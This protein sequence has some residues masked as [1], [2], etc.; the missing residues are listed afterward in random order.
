MSTTV[1]VYAHNLVCIDLCGT[2]KRRAI[3]LIDPAFVDELEKEFERGR[4]WGCRHDLGGGGGGG[5]GALTGEK[6]SS[7]SSSYSAFSGDCASLDPQRRESELDAMLLRIC[8]AYNLSKLVRWIFQNCRD[9]FRAPRLDSAA[10]SSSPSSSASSRE[11][12]IDDGDVQYDGIRSDC[13]A[14][15]DECYSVLLKL[16]AAKTIEYA[17]FLLPELMSSSASSSSRTMRT[18]EKRLEGFTDYL[19]DVYEA[20]ERRLYPE[21]LVRFM[22]ELWREIARCFARMIAEMFDR[23]RTWPAEDGAETLLQSISYLV[24]FMKVILECQTWSLTG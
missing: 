8:N 14:R 11:G 16:L 19:V 3:Q 18:I 21:C 17:E 1:R 5:G 2:A 15:V 22:A 10:S 4:V 6:S 24:K 7:S 9:S 23:N 12:A 20:A 13:S